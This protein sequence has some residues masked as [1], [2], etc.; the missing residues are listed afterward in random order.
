MILT[1]IDILQLMIANKIILTIYLL[2]EKITVKLQILFIKNSKSKKIFQVF[3]FFNIYLE[4]NKIKEQK[5]LHISKSKVNFMLIL[6]RIY[7]E[8]SFCNRQQIN[9]LFQ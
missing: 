7:F 5:K 9:N 1:R 2:C 3:L 8:N 6:S 4:R